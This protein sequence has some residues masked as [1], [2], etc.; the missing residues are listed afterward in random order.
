VRILLVEDDSDVRHAVSASL[1]RAGFAVDDCSTLA[2]GQALADVNDYDCWVL[3]RVL[4]DGDALDQLVEWRSEGRVTPA[5]FLTGRSEVAERVAGFSAGGDDYL[6]KPFAMEELTARVLR[7]CRQQEPLVPAS[8]RIGDLEL[9]WS[10]REVR[11]G[12]VLLALT[13]K[14]LGI[15]RLLMAN[16][17][18]V[19]TKLDLMQHCWSDRSELRA[20][21]IE[22]HIAGLRRKLGEPA[23]IHT[24][25]GAGYRAESS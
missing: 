17:G 10:R 5:L 18:T 7:L 15:L 3:D 16:E 1:G 6:P 19:V 14:E 23:V 24:V 22:V 11:R 4:P 21:T 25:R 13:A 9:D 8:L 2:R 12:G 20:N